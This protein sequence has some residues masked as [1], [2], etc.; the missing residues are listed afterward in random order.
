MTK[1]TDKVTLARALVAAQRDL[2]GVSKGSENKFQHYKYAS[3][4]D[5]M[6]AC[7]AALHANG[8]AARR[9]RWTIEADE[10]HHW[11]VASYELIHE[12]GEM[13]SFVMA[14]R[15]PFSEEKGRTLDK[16]LAG[17]L[18]SSFGYWLRDLLLVPRDDEEMDKRDTREHDP[19]VLGISRAGKLRAQCSKVGTTIE[20]LRDRLR[21]TGLQLPDDP[22]QWPAASA[23]AI[24]A[25]LKMSA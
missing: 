16:A 15:W 24:A 6:S 11:C 18:T 8:L 4:D 9:S 21:E 12:S 5:M 1:Q 22:V 2:K 14:T 23:T 20:A 17:A 3:A 10:Q 25:A 19:Q 13:E 7:R